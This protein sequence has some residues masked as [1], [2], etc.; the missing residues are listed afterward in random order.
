[1]ID[2][3]ASVARNI[4]QLQEQ[5]AAAQVALKKKTCRAE[6]ESAYVIVNMNLQ[7]V[8]LGLKTN[9]TG[10]LLLD[11]L[12][13]LVNAAMCAA[14]EHARHEMQLAM[15]G[16]QLDVKPAVAEFEY[17]DALSEGDWSFRP[18]ARDIHREIAEGLA[19]GI[20][21]DRHLIKF[22]IGS[23]LRVHAD[24]P[25][26]E[27]AKFQAGRLRTLPVTAAGQQF[28]PAHLI[29]HIV[30]QN[31]VA[32]PHPM[33]IIDWA[34]F[35]VGVVHPFL[36]GNRRACWQF[37]NLFLASEGFR[38]VPWDAIRSEWEN[39]IHTTTNISERTERMLDCILRK[40]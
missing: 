37:C 20:R 16:L 17:K 21:S 11:E 4:V 22:D 27:E 18:V 31:F 32:L 13:S 14:Q 1:M 15:K 2:S 10:Q 9:I 19:C 23:L 25:W 36:D 29:P 5:V 34:I 35:M 8:D 26:L 40:I 39:L 7:I 33:C 3:P 30:E 6:S 24:L 28:P 38:P 12:K